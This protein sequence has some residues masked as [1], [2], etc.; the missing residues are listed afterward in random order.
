VERKSERMKYNQIDSQI[1]KAEFK[2]HSVT[3]KKKLDPLEQN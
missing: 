2:N 3:G 1:G